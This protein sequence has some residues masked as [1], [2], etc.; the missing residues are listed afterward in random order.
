[1][2]RSRGERSITNGYSNGAGILC[3]A[4]NLQQPFPAV[5]NVRWVR[6]VM[7][8]DVLT[9][10]A[11]M[12]VVASGWDA[13]ADRAGRPLLGADWFLACAETLCA[14]SD[15]R[16]VIVRSGGVLHAVAPLV[17]VRRDGRNCLEVLG[18]SVLYE[19]TGFLFDSVQALDY[20]VD[21]IVSL[22][23]PMVLARIPAESP[24]EAT[25]K[26]LVC[27][28]GIMLG[29]TGASAAYVVSRGG[30]KEY[31]WSISAQRRYDYQ[32]KRKR[33]EQAGQVAVRIERPDS[34]DDLPH[35]LQEV[36]RIE[37]AGW[38]GRSGSALR[39]NERV[40]KFITRY[41]ELACDRG[42]LRVCFLEVK[43]IPIAT[44]LGIEQ[45]H[46]F[47]VLKIGYD[48]QWARCSPGIQLTM[49]TI[50]YAF[51]NGLESYEFLGSEEL[52]QAMWPRFRHSLVTLVL[53]PISLCGFWAFYGDCR[54]VFL[55]RITQAGPLCGIFRKMTTDN[56][57]R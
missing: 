57:S 12:Q 34:R 2:I 52:W 32:R 24:I 15:L 37:G 53:Y 51:D 31:F 56:V 19:P 14:E 18:A 39:S 33:M 30:W 10:I 50:R 45:G 21:K 35:M 44:I 9:R 36:F 43:G 11:D 1:M 20:L 38:K 46:R 4:S 8:V 47:W 42:S 55:S 16:V 49:E 54:R 41:S 28:R 26:R 13:L 48:E 6:K 25:F 23:V 17:L 5:C 7:D 3:G 22:R 40:R 29:R 27:Y